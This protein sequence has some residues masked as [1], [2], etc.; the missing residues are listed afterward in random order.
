MLYDIFKG[1]C[2]FFIFKNMLNL[3][4]FDEVEIR[5]FKERLLLTHKMLY[6][7][8]SVICSKYGFKNDLDGLG[9]ISKEMMWCFRFMT[10]ERN[11][12]NNK[13]LC[14]Y[15]STIIYKAELPKMRK[16]NWS[17]SHPNAHLC[18]EIPVLYE[19]SDERLVKLRDWV[20][21]E[22]QRRC[23]FNKKRSN[24]WLK[25]KKIEELFNEEMGS[26]NTPQNKVQTQPQP[27]QLF[28]PLP[29][30]L[31]PPPLPF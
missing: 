8:I 24:N 4:D 25:K 18:F 31:P 11:I 23:E 20:F 15:K 12:I 6:N 21:D 10:W 3:Y 22:L 26:N 19:M 13:K 17:I 29:P 5:L 9:K 2:H 28:Q 7:R 1:I 27:Q 14:D 30:P 16:E